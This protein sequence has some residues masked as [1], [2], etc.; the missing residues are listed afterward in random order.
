MTVPPVLLPRPCQVEYRHRRVSAH[1]DPN[2]S[3]LY[4][5][6]MALNEILFDRYAVGL[7]GLR[8]HP[9]DPLMWAGPTSDR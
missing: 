9:L 7:G 5:D 3:F 8:V 2:Q 1:E 6:Q 4:D